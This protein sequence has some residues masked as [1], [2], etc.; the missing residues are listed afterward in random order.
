MYKRLVILLTLML[1]IVPFASVNAQSL[2]EGLDYCLFLAADDCQIMLQSEAVMSDVSSFAFDLALTFNMSM[3]GEG[4]GSMGDMNFGI[5][6]NGMLA[7]DKAS[8]TAFEG[9]D[10]SSS[11]DQMP[12]ML[13]DLFA[14]IDGEAY[15]E[16]SLPQMVAMMTG[17]ATEIPV[18]VLIKDGVYAL[19]VAALETALGSDPSGMGW[20]GI[21]L[22]GAFESMMDEMDMSA[23]GANPMMGG[24]SQFTPEALQDAITITRLADS[25]VDGAPVAVFE[26]VIDYGVLLQSPE[27]VD[28]FN[29]MYSGMDMDQETIDATLAMLNDVKIFVTQYIGLEDSYN[30][31]MDVNMDFAV[32]SEMMGDDSLD[33]AAF[34]F[35]MSFGMSNFNAPVNI[36]L[37]ENA[38]IM[39]ASM[40]LDM[41]YSA[42][43]LVLSAEKYGIIFAEY[44]YLTI[45]KWNMSKDLR[46]RRNDFSS[47]NLIRCDLNLL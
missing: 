19:D 29:S 14:A 11:M 1:A 40:L 2:D 20:A 30:Y 33:S 17:G 15:L 27:M 9:M 6:G 7:V 28:T 4:M 24:M 22:N 26:M 16:I 13:D 21:N 46:W 32:G 3:E 25:D 47:S 18:N 42:E 23:M 41:S 12:A 44:Q 38:M 35:S 31:G 10:P 5:N 39:P 36:V 8:L 37:P 34:S 45:K 43:G